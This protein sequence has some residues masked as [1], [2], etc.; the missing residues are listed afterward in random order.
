MDYEGKYK[1]D[2]NNKKN[3]K[4]PDAEFGMVGIARGFGA[5]IS[6]LSRWNHSS[7]SGSGVSGSILI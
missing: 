1:K 3:K 2:N 7:L 5:S 6:A 4:I